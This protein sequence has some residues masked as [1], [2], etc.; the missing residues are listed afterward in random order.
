MRTWKPRPGGPVAIAPNV[1]FWF[2]PQKHLYSSPLKARR[3]TY[4]RPKREGT[5]GGKKNRASHSPQKVV[6]TP[7]GVGKTSRKEF[8]GVEDPS[9]SWF[10][11]GSFWLLKTSPT[12]QVPSPTQKKDLSHVE[13]QKIRTPS[14]GFPAGTAAVF[15]DS[16]MGSLLSTGA[17]A[18]KSARPQKFHR[19]DRIARYG[20]MKRLRFAHHRNEKPREKNALDIYRP[21]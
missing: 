19:A 7:C 15:R 9:I 17:R 8:V 11:S 12:K 21:M 20:S 18:S 4:R 5:S 10:V 2:H 14:L 3:D 16:S 13:W 1:G 6:A